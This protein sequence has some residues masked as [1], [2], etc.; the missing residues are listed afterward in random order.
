GQVVGRRGT[1]R[2]KVRAY[3]GGGW[4]VRL[5]VRVLHCTVY[6][7]RRK[8]PCSSKAGAKRWG[9]ERANFLVRQG[10]KPERKEIPTLEEFNP[11]FISG[12]CEANRQKPS[13]IDSK[14][15]YLRLYV[16]PL[17][18]KKPLDKIADEDVQQ[19]K[20]TMQHLSPKTANNALTVLAKMLRV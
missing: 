16:E 14:K 2:G 17:M 15:T 10:C 20:A 9:E 4:A 11:R 8:A 1:L 5:R 18:G 6:R 19:L 3:R 12:Y 13:G 7:E